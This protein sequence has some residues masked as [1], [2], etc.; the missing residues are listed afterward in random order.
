MLD[1]GRSKHSDERVRS[2]FLPYLTV[3]ALTVS[4]PE[5][6]NIQWDTLSRAK[7]AAAFMMKTLD[8][9]GYWFSRNATR[10]DGSDRSL[11]WLAGS[12]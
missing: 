4:T 9:T 12:E 2:D 3:P 6:E 8:R 5:G 11:R 10:S 7:T 1:L